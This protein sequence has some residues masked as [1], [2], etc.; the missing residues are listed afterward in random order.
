M[1]PIQLRL[2]I[3]ITLMIVSLQYFTKYEKHVIKIVVSR[4]RCISYEPLGSG[5]YT[6]HMITM[7]AC[8]Y[9]I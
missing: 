4:G 9:Y 8:N 3:Q 6:L 7:N 1:I 5:S 2:L